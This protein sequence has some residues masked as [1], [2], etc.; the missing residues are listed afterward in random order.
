M[1]RSRGA[2]LVELLF[3]LAGICVALLVALPAFPDPDGDEPPAGHS[4]VFHNSTLCSFSPMHGAGSRVR[5]LRYD[6]L[7]KR[8]QE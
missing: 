4:S 7:A 8:W 5:L 3:L 2:S 1:R 6:A